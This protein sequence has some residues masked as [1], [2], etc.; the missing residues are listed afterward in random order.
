MTDHVLAVQDVG[1]DV[2]WWSW[3]NRGATR[4]RRTGVR[5]GTLTV[6]IAVSLLTWLLA[7]LF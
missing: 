1:A 5:M 4:D 3:Y 2:R 6:L 7:G